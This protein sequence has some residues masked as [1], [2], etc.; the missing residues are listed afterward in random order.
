MSVCQ[1]PVARDRFG[2]SQDPSL[3]L[4]PLYKL[5]TRIHE[6][7]EVP[8]VPRLDGDQPTLIR[9][10]NIYKYSRIIHA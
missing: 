1:N 5:G 6:Q 7:P 9:T 10:T 3:E 4:E 8:T 2:P